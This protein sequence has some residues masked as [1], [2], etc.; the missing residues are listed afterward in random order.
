MSEA[1]LLLEE[2]FQYKE[3][4]NE[5]AKTLS[6]D[7]VLYVED[8]GM[9]LV[10]YIPSPGFKESLTNSDYEDTSDA[11]LGT[12]DMRENSTYKSNEIGSIFAKPGYGPLLYQLAMTVS[13]KFGLMPTRQSTKIT[14]AA[15]AVWKNFFDG[16]GKK[17][18]HSKTNRSRIS[19]PRRRLFE[20]PIFY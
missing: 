16:K 15:K 13:G 2:Y 19:T 7:M 20:L 18:S 4:I 8:D 17:F 6:S 10:L 1:T 11:V 14:D 12:V 3:S 9:F 5:A